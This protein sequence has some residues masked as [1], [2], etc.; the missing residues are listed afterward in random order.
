MNND[1]VINMLQITKILQSFIIYLCFAWKSSWPG[2]YSRARPT[3][4]V[5]NH[6]WDDRCQ[7]DK[8][9][10]PSHASIT[11]QQKLPTY[12]TVKTNLVI[13]NLVIN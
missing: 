13:T 4:L 10:R 8:T 1:I 3:S 6:P 5:Q 2:V 9:I 12:A 11:T 7:F